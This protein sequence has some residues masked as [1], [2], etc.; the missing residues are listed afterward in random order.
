MRVTVSF[1][2][3][4]RWS[5]IS[6]RSICKLLIFSRRTF[7][8]NVLPSPTEIM[9]RHCRQFAIVSFFVWVIVVGRTLTLGQDDAV[10][11]VETS[12][13]NV[14]VVV[15]NKDGSLPKGLTKEDFELT[16]NGTRKPID[17]FDDK[18]AV[19]IAIIIDA[20]SNTA[21]VL[22]RI[23]RDAQEF[24]D[25]LNSDEMAMVIRLDVAGYRVMCELSSD[26]SKLAG[27]RQNRL[28]RDVKV[29][30]RPAQ[31]Y[32]TNLVQKGKKRV[33]VFRGL[34]SSHIVYEIRPNPGIHRTSAQSDS[35]VYP[36][37]INTHSPRTKIPRPTF[38]GLGN[39][40]YRKF[41][42]AVD[43]GSVHGE[44]HF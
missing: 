1:E 14:P 31:Q 17:F 4:S 23:K 24:I 29:M 7:E 44:R 26:R 10:I 9:W 8:R 12:V 28:F 19:N 35:T 20:N 40:P 38:C 37:F 6:R 32:F 16:V 39:L 11:K 3:R 30:V 34:I 5:G 2:P 42:H 36:I 43:G 15:T 13:V 41:N 25:L 27:R 33:N 22:G 18:G 21:D